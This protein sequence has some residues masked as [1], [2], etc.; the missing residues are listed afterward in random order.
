LESVI[1]PDFISYESVFYYEFSTDVFE[2]GSG[3]EQRVANWTD[4]RLVGDLATAIRSESNLQNV[5]DT[6]VI[7]KGRLN[8][9]RMKYHLDWQIT[10][11]AIGS[12]DGS[13]TSFQ[14][15][16]TYSV[17]S[18]SYNRNITKPINDSSLA[19]YLSSVAQTYSSDY[20]VAFS[21]GIIT[22][23]A[24]PGS[25]AAITADFNFHHPMRFDTDKL[26]TKLEAYTSSG[27][28]GKATIPVLEV[29]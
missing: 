7:C 10:G 23:V 29:R 8:G 14:M 24:A 4:Y 5:I 17:S 25:G 18:E 20:T 1:L 11:Q 26:S 21:T 6:F 12:G 15:V 3:A 16:R 28:V 19:V 27:F 9:F 22:F 13:E 2:G